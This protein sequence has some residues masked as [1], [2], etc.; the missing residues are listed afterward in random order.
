MTAVTVDRVARALVA[1]LTIMG[2]ILTFCGAVIIAHGIK[3]RACR[4]AEKNKTYEL[5]CALAPFATAAREYRKMLPISLSPDDVLAAGD[6]FEKYH[7]VR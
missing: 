3:D 1:F 5:L 6:A 7:E 4:V 2:S